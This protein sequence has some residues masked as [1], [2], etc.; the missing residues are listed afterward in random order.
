[1]DAIKTESWEDFEEKL[2]KLRAENGT[3]ATPLLYRGQ[4]NSEWQLETTL[5]R[6]TKKEG[7]TFLGYYDL[8]T[9]GIGPEVRTFS[10]VDVPPR[11]QD[12]ARS[13]FDKDLMYKWPREFPDLPSIATWLTCGNLV[14]PHLCSTGRNHRM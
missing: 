9:G 2:K 10:G 4:G 3:E 6:Y 12:I 11:R 13:F 8:I 14:S 1:M 5:E 7:M